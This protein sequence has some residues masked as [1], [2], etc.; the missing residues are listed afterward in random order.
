MNG[1]SFGADCQ[2]RGRVSAVVGF[3]DEDGEEAEVVEEDEGGAVGWLDVTG[4]E[5]DSGAEH[6]EDGDVGCFIDDASTTFCS[7]QRGKAAV[8]DEVGDLYAAAFS[9]KA[10]P[11]PPH[12]S[13]ALR[14]AQDGERGRDDDKAFVT[15]FDG[16]KHIV[17]EFEPFFGGGGGIELLPVH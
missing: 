16:L 11:C 7:A 10:P 4:D 3:D 15:R 6:E 13:T 1:S 17:D 12:P 14:S 5:E 2:L 9:D 8:V